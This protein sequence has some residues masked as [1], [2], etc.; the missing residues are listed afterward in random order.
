MVLV[1]D[2]I[3]GKNKLDYGG[4]LMKGL[5]SMFLK[6]TNSFKIFTKMKK[7]KIKNKVKTVINRDFLIELT[8]FSLGGDQIPIINNHRWSA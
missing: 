3:M 4:H 7:N 8:T 1:V 5:P 2:T 6:M